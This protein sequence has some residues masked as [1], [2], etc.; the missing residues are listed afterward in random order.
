MTPENSDSVLPWRLLRIE[1]Q[2]Y[3]RMTITAVVLVAYFFT[4]KLGL[5]FASVE[6]N[7]TA[8]WAPSG[9]SLAACLLFGSWIWP[10]IWAGAF[11]VNATTYGSIA[12]SIAI[13]IGN[14]AEALT[15]AYLVRRFAHGRHAFNRT[16]EAF[17]FV[18]FAA[19]LS[20]T[21][22]ATVG[23]TSLC[24][25]GY[26]S[27]SKFVWIWFTWWMGDGTG[28]LI[29]APPLILWARFSGTEWDRQK[30]IEAGLLVGT[31]LLTAGVVFGG[32]LPFWGPQYPNAFLCIPVLLW[33]AFRFGPRETAT[34]VF[35]LSL[36]AIGATVSSVGP[37]SQG[38][39]NESLLLVQAFVAVA[40]TSHLLVAIEVA[41]RQRLDKTRRRLGAVVESSDD[42][43][44]AITPEGRIT[45]WNAGAERLYGFSA[46]ET[47]GNPVSIIIPADRMSE[48]A[49][50]LSRINNGETI[51][52]FE[53]VRLRKNGL[54]T[55]V[56]LTVSPLKDGGGRIIGASKIARD[57]TRLKQ[58][59]QEREALLL[60]ERAARDAAE[61]AREAAEAANR[62]KDEFLAMLGHELRNPL[63][64]ISLASQL[65]QKPDSLG[66]AREII[67]RQ[68]AHMSRLVD[69]LLDAA[70]VTS[71]RIVLSRRSLNLA[72]LV[73]DCIDNL[74]ETGQLERHLVETDF[75]TVWVDGDYERLSQVVINL[76]GN[77]L[78]YTPPGGQIWVHVKASA[79]AVIQVQDNGA[80][81]SSDILPGIFELFARGEFGLQRSPAGLGI[82]L[83][84]VKRIAELHGGRAEAVSEGPGRGSTFTIR[85][86]R[87]AAPQARH[88]ERD[89]KPN[90]PIGPRRI[91]LVEDNDDER[92]CLRLL[93]EASG[94][95]I[96]EAVD[97]PGGVERSLEV[98][99]EVVLIDLGL[100]GLDGYEVAARI[101][102][103]PLCRAATLIALTGYGQTE[104]RAKAEMAGFH[105]Y[106]VKPVDAGALEKLLAERPVPPNGGKTQSNQ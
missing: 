83:T 13:A 5:S 16:T 95:E 103:A 76:L 49:E 93:L 10:A 38:S 100:P 69:D 75:E 61:R 41:E 35:L 77:A 96:H 72:A 31:L 8:I 56:S 79:E 104:Y 86:P 64:A 45:D 73:S 29:V 101:R 54:R 85:L 43:I 23:V 4:A 24:I 26:S 52:P 20:T 92:E 28:D 25:G 57:I 40:G 11:L 65:L 94:H 80:G 9:L 55:E 14:T 36:A 90:G 67:T 19:V 89:G 88:I 68:G 97:G 81:I 53:T 34:V 105:G 74:R 15:G 21:V 60:S 18:L 1:S 12:T 46:A 37:F 2:T 27:W 33:T 3:T 7:A 91:L 6:P 22:S 58:A 70:R 106:L 44:I 50:V 84:L 59:R 82:G 99:P 47:I 17:R 42:A 51:A 32:L 30:N 62:A 63:H 98:Q 66:K 48:S 102:S 78:K 87:I 71:G 39:R